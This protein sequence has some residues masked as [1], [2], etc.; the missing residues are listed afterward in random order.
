MR[1]MVNVGTVAIY[2]LRCSLPVTRSSCWS[3]PYCDEMLWRLDRME[4]TSYLARIRSQRHLGSLLQ[5][6]RCVLSCIL[7]PLRR[8]HIRSTIRWIS[9]QQC[10]PLPA[11]Q[12][13]DRE[14]ASFSRSHAQLQTR[15]QSYMS[16]PSCRDHCF[17]SLHLP[18]WGQQILVLNRDSHWA[19]H[20]SR[21]KATLDPKGER[22]AR[23]L[24]T[25]TCY[26]NRTA[27]TLHPS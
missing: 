25:S 17:C 24:L 21:S 6:S 16:P 2:A 18:V 12:P 13:R 9:Q 22:Y 14:V 15:R 8:R 23:N 10:S 20:L 5:V 1:T 7:S 3:P 11:S 19:L 26:S 27:K 4:R